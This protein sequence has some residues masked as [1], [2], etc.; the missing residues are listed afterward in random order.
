M[1]KDKF[2]A[3]RLEPEVDRLL[4]QGIEAYFDDPALARQYFRDAFDLF[5]EPLKQIFCAHPRGKSPD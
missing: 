3:E 5:P 1:I 2:E 4:Q